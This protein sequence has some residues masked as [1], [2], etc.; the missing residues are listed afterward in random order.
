[1]EGLNFYG[2]CQRSGVYR[3]VSPR[4][5]INPVWLGSAV[6]RIVNVIKIIIIVYAQQQ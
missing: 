1:M 4:I 5:N 6:V 2:F 3:P